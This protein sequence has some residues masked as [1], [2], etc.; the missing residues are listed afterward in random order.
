[1]FRGE[2]TV[3]DGVSLTGLATQRYNLPPLHRSNQGSKNARRMALSSGRRGIFFYASTIKAIHEQT[4]TNPK[5][6]PLLINST[7]N[8]RFGSNRPI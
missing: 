4:K 3:N 8:D 5:I 6:L 7:L 1:M 2:A